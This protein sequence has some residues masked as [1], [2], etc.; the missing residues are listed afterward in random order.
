MPDR[1]RARRVFLGSLVHL[2]LQAGGTPAIS[3][4]LRSRLDNLRIAQPRGGPASAKIASVAAGPRRGASVGVTGSGIGCSELVCLKN[5]IGT[6]S[7]LASEDV[8]RI[9]R[10]GVLVGTD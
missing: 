9:L 8:S 1:G 6:F 7:C 4:D 3:S 5:N 10:E 2:A